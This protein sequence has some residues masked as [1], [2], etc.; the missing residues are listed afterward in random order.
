MIIVNI[1]KALSAFFILLLIV[2]CSTTQGVP[3]PDINNI[4]TKEAIIQVNRPSSL[5]G[6][7]RTVDIYDFDKKI[8]ELGSG[9]TL[10]WSR[11]E[12]K[13]CLGTRQTNL[14]EQKFDIKCFVAEGGKVTKFQF[15]Y[16]KAEFTSEGN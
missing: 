12:G 4:K 3:V 11:P 16:L 8:G 7:A 10:T 1:F 5:L 2:G 13:T 14:F 15:D 9:G 6:G